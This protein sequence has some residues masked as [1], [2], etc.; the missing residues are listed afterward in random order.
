MKTIDLT[1]GERTLAEVLALARHERILIRSATGDD[2]LLE[3]ANALDREVALLGQGE[4]FMS[5]LQE[6]SKE[7]GATPLGEIRRMR[8]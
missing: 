7:P 6:R 1:L 3:P 5:F 2:F 4:R 8:E